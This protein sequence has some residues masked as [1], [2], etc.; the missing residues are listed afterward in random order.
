MHD[1]ALINVSAG[2]G[3][4]GIV[5][6]RREKYIP[7]GGPDGGDG[8]SGGDVYIES[9]TRVQNLTQFVRVKNYQAKNGVSGQGSNKTG[10]GGEDLVLTVPC[11]TIISIQKGDG[12]QEKIDLTQDGQKILIAKGG[13]GGLGNIHF[14]SSTNRAPRESTKGEPGESFVVKFDLKLLA[15]VGLIGIP[16]AGKSSLL[17]KISNAHPKIGDYQF[18]TLEPNLGKV[19]Y[20][21]SNFIVADI[22]GLIEGASQG[23]GLGDEFL[24]HIERTNILVHL[25]SAESND[26]EKDYNVI[27]QEIK[28]YN[29][30]LLRKKEIIV[31][32]KTDL[33]Q[34]NTKTDKFIKKYKPI[35]LSIYDKNSIDTLLDQISIIL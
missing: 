12:W 24:R 9:S 6:F 2:K 28:E 29:P 31:I 16:N 3:G 21:N 32:S 15:Q 34:I 20:K 19:N 35:L 5:S 23:R 4:D 11:G 27:R 30:N 26:I 7:K 8:G 1:Q 25:I 18:T 13:K 17:D 33:Y 10:K 22:P 14:K